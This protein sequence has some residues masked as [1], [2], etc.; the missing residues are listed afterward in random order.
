MR[1]IL[2]VAQREYIETVKTKTFLVGILMTPFLI[3]AIIFFT[4]RISSN[5][6]GPRPPKK[7]TID[8]FSGELS[9]QIKELFDEYNSANPNRQILLQEVQNG[10]NLEAIANREKNKVRQ[11]RLDAYVVLEKDVLEGSGKIRLYTGDTRAS[12]FDVLMIIE[13]LINR[14]VVN[15][16]CRLRDLSPQLLAEIRRR[17]PAQR[18][19]VG[20]AADKEHIQ[21]QSD[22]ITNMM[23]PFFFMFMIFMGV[24]GMGQHMVSSVIEEKSSRVIEVLLSAL[25]PFQLMTGKIVGLAGIGITVMILWGMS[26]YLVSLWRGISLG[27]S[28]MIL[29]YFLIY[30]LLGFLLFSSILAAIGSICNTIKESQ[31]LMMPI[32]FLCVLPMVS[33][34]HL[35]QNPE[36]TYARVLS[37]VPPL[38]PMVMILRICASPDLAPIEILASIALLAAS[39]PAVMWVG[40]KVFRT[41][42]LMYGKRPR[43]REVIRWMKQ[44]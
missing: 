36:S 4:S 40:A 30:Y 16:R 13:N 25:N 44:S 42:I 12:D 17:V 2:K 18:I 10:E 32:S 8:D 15:L 24:F 43:L 22:I 37:F 39:V 34:F 1:K 38:T 21:K 41:G 6:E 33:W 31:S 29:L 28:A 27:I 35:A 14:A 7:V 5:V 3:V 20:S 23:V 11:G 19:E 26:A 9:T